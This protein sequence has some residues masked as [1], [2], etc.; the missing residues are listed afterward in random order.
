[1]KDSVQWSPLVNFKSSR[2]SLVTF[3][4]GK[5]NRTQKNELLMSLPCIENLFF[6]TILRGEGGI[7]NEENHDWYVLQS[8]ALLDRSE[9]DMKE[10]VWRYVPLFEIKTL[11]HVVHVNVRLEDES[12][13]PRYSLN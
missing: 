4:A 12:V 1:M 3:I 13:H 2:T 9:L 6:C 8:T 11:P 7:I 10:R 5:M